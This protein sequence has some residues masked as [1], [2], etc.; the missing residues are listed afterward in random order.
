MDD[1]YIA[2][3]LEKEG[4]DIAPSILGLLRDSHLADSCYAY[5]LRTKSESKLLEKRDRKRREKPSYS[6]ADITDVVG[7]RLVALFKGDMADLFESTL[8]AMLHTNGVSPNPLRKGI[9]EEVVI[10]KGHA[11][12][13]DLVPRIKELTS[14]LCPDLMVLERNSREG[15]SSIHLVTRLEMSTSTASVCPTGRNYRIPLE[16]QIRT[17]F[18][19]AWGEIDH[20]YGYVIR[21]GKE[22]GQPINNP[23][24]VLSHLKVLKRFSDACMEYAE[25][26]RQEAVGAP[27]EAVRP[28]AVISVASDDDIL[29]RFS[30]LCVAQDLI[31]CYQVARQRKEDATEL[32]KRERNEGDKLLLESAEMFRELGND[33]VQDGSSPEAL[34]AGMRLF[35]YYVRMNEAL[36]LMATNVRDNV[37]AAHHIYK[38]LESHY[39]EFPLL[40]MRA[41][42]AF[43]KLGQVAP[44]LTRLREAGVAAA[45]IAKQVAENGGAW[46]DELPRTDYDHLVRVQP[47][48]VGYHI[49]LQILA[50]KH[51]HEIE[52]ADLFFQAY[53]VT[54]QSIESVTEDPEE[55]ASIH[56]NLLYYAIGYLSRAH[57]IT[58]DTREKS[59]EAALD[60]HIEFLEERAHRGIPHSVNTL[61][62]LM[63]AYS[64][65]GKGDAACHAAAQIKD[66]CLFADNSDIGS[67][68]RLA[69]LQSAEKVLKGMPIGLID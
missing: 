32:R 47:K 24:H 4:N 20:K 68:N 7:L 59:L 53:D 1:K 14:N 35:Y 2:L 6:L 30:A 61:D 67:D 64:L 63:K 18:E 29:R 65:R 13:D 44:A 55:L 43:G 54:S 19:D 56:N 46:P 17:V 41:G 50:L 58:G 37:L 11:A 3:W 60:K 23:E 10:Y 39:S 66:I 9:P 38:T 16:I 33:I 34:A 57:L 8:R 51:G 36:C 49:W 48:L 5:K 12:F 40:K 31:E 21:S 27:V 26:I 45:Q 25:S 69:L 62:T 52:K 15:Y 28:T 22:S 42:Q